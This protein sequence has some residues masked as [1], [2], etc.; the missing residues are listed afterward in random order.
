L[1]AGAAVWSNPQSVF[2]IVP[3]ALVCAR[4]LLRNVKLVALAVPF[5]VVGAAPWLVYSVRNDWKTLRVPGVDVY[6][7]YSER[8]LLFFRQLPIVFGARQPMNDRWIV[9]SEVFVVVA[10]ALGA[11]LVVAAVKNVKG[12]RI[13]V[14][15]IVGYA[16]LYGVSP[17]GGQPGASLQPRYLLFVTPVVALAVAAVVAWSR[18]WAPAAGIAVLALTVVLAAIGLHAMDTRRTTLLSSA[19]GVSIPADISD[20]TS[21]LRDRGIHHAY[22]FYWIAYRTT[23]ETEED[24]IVDPAHWHVSRYRPYADAVRNSPEPAAVIVLAGTPQVDAMRGLFESKQ[25]AYEIH[26]R[27]AFAVIEPE[28]KVDREEVAVAF[29]SVGILA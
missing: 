6:L 2:L 16:L 14:A 1:T 24:V 7:P 27:G 26:E 8:V 18:R 5:A 15:V 20:L 29:R 19:P 28:E 10:V 9:P 12:A 21:L 22:S 3:F 23:F 4:P 25:I 13:A 11:A 17:Q